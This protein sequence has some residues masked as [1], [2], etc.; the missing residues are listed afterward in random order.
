MIFICQN[1]LYAEHTAYA[2]STGIGRIADRAASYGMLGLHVDGNDPLA[3]YG[4]AKEAIDR[5]RSG[6]G[7]TLIEAMTFRFNGHLIGDM[8]EY[9]PKAQYA[10]AV[11]NDPFPKYRDWLLHGEHA[12]EAELHAIDEAVR[13]EIEEAQAFALESPFPDAIEVRRDV[14]ADEIA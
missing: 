6:E 12:E 7:P 2:E 14:F 5:A 9:I 11:A 1:N 13:Q 8:G 3:I 10:E 4:A